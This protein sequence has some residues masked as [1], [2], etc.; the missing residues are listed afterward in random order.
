MSMSRIGCYPYLQL[1][2]IKAY[3]KPLIGL[4]ISRDCP[5]QAFVELCFTFLP[6]SADV[7]VLST[8]WNWCVHEPWIRCL[9]ERMYFPRLHDSD[10]LEALSRCTHHIA[11]SAISQEAAI[12]S[13][14]THCPLLPRVLCHMDFV[15]DVNHWEVVDMPAKSIQV[16]D[17]PFITIC[18]PAYEMST[19]G[20][21]FLSALLLSI[22]TQVYDRYHVIVSDHSES[23]DIEVFCKTFPAVTYL[24]NFQHAGSASGNINHAID[25]AV[26]HMIKP[27]FQDDFF[28]TNEALSAITASYTTSK[29]LWCVCANIP[30]DVDGKHNGHVFSPSQPDYASLLRGHNTISCPSAV[31]WILAA[32][33]RFKAWSFNYMDCILYAELLL[34]AKPSF[35]QIPQIC[36]RA[37]SGSVTSTVVTGDLNTKEQAIICSQILSQ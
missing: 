3:S 12:K 2:A 26:G 11:N 36:V 23:C 30:V 34:K 33:I 5:Q 29:W 22:H 27:M 37:W 28:A 13:Q 20:V 32:N 35:V 7:L 21:E 19:K 25:F 9:A 8:D 31:T 24:R 18:I 10:I 4:F 1:D 6:K 15:A 14:V 16:P 17:L